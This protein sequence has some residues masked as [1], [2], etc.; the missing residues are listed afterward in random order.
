MA[1]GSSYTGCAGWSLATTSQAPF[2]PGDSHLQRYAT[3]LNCV[4]INSSFYR[5]H[6]CAT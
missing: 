3:R 4:E 2:G 6:N 1:A 5:P